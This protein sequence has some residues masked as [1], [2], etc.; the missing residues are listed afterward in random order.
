MNHHI[1]HAPW[2]LQELGGGEGGG[3]SKNVLTEKVHSAR[4]K[5]DF[6]IQ[7]ITQSITVSEELGKGTRQKQFPCGSCY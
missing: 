7:G 6:Q 1:A 5:L 3:C 4:V 2:W